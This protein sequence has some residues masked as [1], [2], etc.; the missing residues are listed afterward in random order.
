VRN[1]LSILLLLV[2]VSAV[3]SAQDERAP[4]QPLAA[5]ARPAAPAA[6]PKPTP[7]WPDGRVNLGALPGESGIWAG[8]GRLVVNPQSYEP[9]TTL[10]APIH[11]DKVPLQDWARSLVNFRHGEFLRTE[12]HARCKLS[13]GPREF[14]TP[15]GFEIVDFPDL[16][17]VVVFD[18]GGPHSFRIIYT[19]GRPHPKDL[20]PSYY[21][22][23]IGRWEGDTLVVDAVGFN[24]KFWMSRDGLPHTDRLHL[25]ERFTRTDFNTLKYEVTVDD[26]GAYAAPW[27]SGFSL[28]W[29]PGIELFEY[30]CQGNNFFPEAVFYDA[31]GRS[32]PTVNTVP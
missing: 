8:D 31:E 26:P 11:I 3:P 6:P 25:T 19:D 2:A 5:P 17:R 9:R 15:Y 27:T 12:P 14:V 13:G 24:E 28:R 22:H 18:I 1:G 32:D 4:T 10:N 23:S 30:L 21:G 7:R 20:R 29:Q 16:K